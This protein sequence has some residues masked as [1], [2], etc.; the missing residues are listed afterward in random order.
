[1]TR[2]STSTASPARRWVGVVAALVVIGATWVGV[3]RDADARPQDRHGPFGAVVEAS[4]GTAE[5]GQF[6][7]GDTVV[8]CIDLNSYGP[9]KASGWVT[10]RTDRIRKQTTFGDRGGHTD[11]AGDLITR[12]EIAEL[13]WVLEWAEKHVDDDDSAIAVDHF[14]R[15]RTVGDAGQQARMGNRLAAA[16][17]AYPGVE[18]HLA[19]LERAVK[20]E[21]GPY[22]VQLSLDAEGHTG[23]AQVVG[24]AGKPIAG[25]EIT[26]SINEEERQLVADDGGTATFDLPKL[27]QGQVKVTATATVPGS[28]PVLHTASHYD[29]EGHGDYRIQRMLS[30]GT[31]AT[32]TASDGYRV[33]AD[34]PTVVTVAST[35]TAMV[36]DEV[37]D[38]V[39]ITDAASYRGQATATLWG[40]YAEPPKKDQCRPGDRFAGEVTFDVEGNGTRR[41]PAVRVTEPGHY[42]WTV[43]LPS[44]KGSEAVTTPCG[45]EAETVHVMETPTLRLVGEA[46]Q[47]VVGEDARARLQISGLRASARLQA[48]LWGP[49]EADG[50]L[51]GRCVPGDQVAGRVDLTLD[52]EGDHQTPAIR[53]ERPGLYVWTFELTS[54]DLPEPITTDCDG[55]ATIT[56]TAD[57][58]SGPTPSPEPTPERTPSVTPMPTPTPTP[59]RTVTPTPS[60][61]RSPTPNASPRPEP[62]PSPD[63]TPESTPSPVHT[64]DPI[65]SPRSEP[66]PS[67]VTHEPSPWPEPDTPVRIRSGA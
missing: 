54:D 37:F 35:P 20:D 24:H 25:R 31:P 22:R 28:I 58:D 39:R 6:Q 56:V 3:T 21:A 62:S 60:A 13:A 46:T 5:L 41:T 36:G 55:G 19:A 47:I 48:T 63:R 44:R 67:F 61:R 32:V 57:E 66:E 51:Q 26:V 14:I 29:D 45:I 12:Q 7:L 49:F 1:M 23:T 4:D 65:P 9:Q 8:W 42:T 40:P 2:P 50:S 16:Q 33:S 59:T 53:P 11:V 34:T 10:T 43:T 38:N 18:R 15:L 64:P 17:K 27:D 30:A 52:S